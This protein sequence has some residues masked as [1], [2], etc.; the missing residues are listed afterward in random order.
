[1]D[2][3][4]NSIEPDEIPH[5][6]H[7][8][9]VCLG[10]CPSYWKIFTHVSREL[11]KSQGFEVKVWDLPK[12]EALI[13]DPNHQLEWMKPAWERVR[14]AGEKPHG[15]ARIADFARAI[16]VYIFGGVYLDL[17]KFD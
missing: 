11:A 2:R 17:G 10:P 12:L 1:M 14:E 5:L 8:I 4:V 15:K 6:L 3:S 7:I 13:N 9:T 16:V